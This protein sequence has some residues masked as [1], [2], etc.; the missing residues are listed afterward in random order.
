MPVK[1][2]RATQIRI[3]ICFAGFVGSLHRV[4]GA[5]LTNIGTKGQVVGLSASVLLWKVPTVDA[6][7]HA[8]IACRPGS[9]IS[10]ATV[11]TVWAFMVV[12]NS[13]TRTFRDVG[14]RVGQL[15]LLR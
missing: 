15:G 13:R 9:A 2:V 12:D 5:D 10:G 4:E 7:Q 8:N 14:E 3:W 11:A 6:L 1:R